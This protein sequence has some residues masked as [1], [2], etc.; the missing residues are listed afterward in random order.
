MIEYKFITN[1][2]NCLAHHSSSTIY[3]SSHLIYILFTS[4]SYHY[5]LLPTFATIILLNN[6]LMSDEDIQHFIQYPLHDILSLFREIC[7]LKNFK[8]EGKSPNES[9]DLTPI[10]NLLIML[11]SLFNTYAQKRVVPSTIEKNM[12]G[13]ILSIQNRLETKAITISFFLPLVSSILSNAADAEIWAHL[14]YLVD[15]V[16][17]ITPQQYDASSSHHPNSHHV[18]TT[19]QLQGAD[20]TMEILKDALRKELTG[21]V[22]E[23]VQGF[24]AKFFEKPLWASKCK[25]I[26]ESYANRKDKKS[27]KFPDDRT[28][29]NVWQWITTVQTNFIEPYRDPPTEKAADGPETATA[30]NTPNQPDASKKIKSFPLRGQKFR[31]TNGT[32]IKGGPTFRQVD[33]F[34]KSRSLRRGTP[35][36]WRDIQVLGEFTKSPTSVWMDKFLQLAVYMREVFTAQPLRNFVHGFLLLDT[37]LQLWVFDRSGPYSTGFIEIGENPEVLIYVITAY[38][39]MSDEELGIDTSVRHEKG[40]TIMTVTD[41]ITQE[42]R[43]LILEAEPFVRQKAIVTRGTTCYRALDGTYV[44]KISWRAVDRLSEVSLL[45]QARNVRGVARLIGSW[46]DSKISK[47]REDLTITSEMERDVHPDDTIMTTTVEPIE[48]GPSIPTE[49]HEQSTSAKRKGRAEG[50]DGDDCEQSSKRIRVSDVARSAQEN[51]AMVS[52]QG[53]VNPTGSGASA[54]VKIIRRS[55]RISSR[56][57]IEYFVPFRKSGRASNSECSKS[58]SK[59]RRNPDPAQG[60]KPAMPERE[61]KRLRISNTAGEIVSED[62]IAPISTEVGP[63]TSAPGDR[64]GEDA[65]ATTAAVNDGEADDPGTPE[66]S[67]AYR[68]RQKTYIATEPRGRSIG[69]ETT[70]LDLLQGLRDAI[71]AHRSLFMDT[72]ILHR[73]VSINNIILTDPAVNDGLYGLLIDLDLAISLDDVKSNENRQTMTG[74]MEYIALGILEANIYKNKKGYKHTYRHDLESFFYVLVSACIR[75]G[76]GKKKS[77]GTYILSTWYTGTVRSMYFHKKEAVSHKHFEEC[78]LNHFSTRFNCVKPL[79]KRLRAILF[80]KS[81]GVDTN[82]SPFPDEV[83]DLILKAYD[84]EING[85]KLVEQLTR[86]N[87]ET[88]I[89][90]S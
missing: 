24:Y 45:I 46:D 81:T 72:R 30:V 32:Q 48:A 62:G 67:I 55:T 79:V 85:I 27:F 15:K 13:R 54:T 25:K 70:A 8:I 5:Q 83:Y 73:D 42:P 74:T 58:G 53:H 87:T 1:P 31:T 44:V 23:D 50:S 34:I 47:L 84:D 9:I 52:G 33:F 36:S 18:Y 68:D 60:K 16:E 64:T 76:S 61:L 22:F 86:S 88:L 56:G 20:E 78:V 82:T 12:S 7:Y 14:A 41:A 40:Q 66:L 37:K 51:A 65:E 35:H 38:M 29:A 11:F 4:Y 63:L 90:E 49:S 19:A 89:A 3:H 26:S 57:S 43:T 80:D 17:P 39:L 69:E 77:G 75:F 6:M 10:S 71:L 59:R 28:E 2:S 21:S